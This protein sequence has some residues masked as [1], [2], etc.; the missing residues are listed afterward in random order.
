ML[1]FTPTGKAEWLFNHGF[2]CAKVLG[3][4]TKDL[5]I[6]MSVINQDHPTDL[7][8]GN[9][10]EI[11]SQ[12]QFFYLDEFCLCQFDKTNQSTNKTNK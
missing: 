12:L 6:S 3:P 5:E 11:L 9:K 7:P 2:S 8:K 10:M 1:N 4:I